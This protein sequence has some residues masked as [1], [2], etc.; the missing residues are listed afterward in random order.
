M[1]VLD[2][3]LPIVIIKMSE[4]FSL[5]YK[6][7]NLGSLCMKVF[8]HGLIMGQKGNYQITI[9]NMKFTKTIIINNSNIL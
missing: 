4:I 8:S 1:L 2:M 5:F 7:S 3:I 6:S 9:C